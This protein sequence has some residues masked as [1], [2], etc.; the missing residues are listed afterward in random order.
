MAY[1]VGEVISSLKANNL[2]NNTLVVFMSDHGPHVEMCD[3]GGTTIGLRGDILSLY[4]YIKKS[5]FY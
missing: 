4:K 2:Q 3:H 5:K 1:A